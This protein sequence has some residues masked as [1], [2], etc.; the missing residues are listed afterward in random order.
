MNSNDEEHCHEMIRYQSDERHP[1]ASLCA[2]WYITQE[3]LTYDYR[4]VS[5]PFFLVEYRCSSSSPPS[6]SSYRLC[7]ARRRQSSSRRRNAKSTSV[8]CDVYKL[9]FSTRHHRLLYVLDTHDSSINKPLS[10]FCL[11]LFSCLCM[12]VCMINS[13]RTRSRRVISCNNTSRRIRTNQSML[14]VDERRE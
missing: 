12:Y 1:E 3:I 10:L 14:S 7:V 13:G 8:G 6:P 5:L 2:G 4:M 11:F 9:I